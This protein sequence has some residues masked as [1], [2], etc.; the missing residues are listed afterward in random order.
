MANNNAASHYNRNGVAGNIRVGG[1]DKTNNT[2]SSAGVAASN[3]NDVCNFLQPGNLNSAFNLAP[4]ACSYDHLVEMIRG[5]DLQDDGIKM[6]H[7]IGA[8]RS[9]FCMLVHDENMLW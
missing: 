6:N 4:G 7:K 2:E 1:K 8:I 3:L 9:D 5:L